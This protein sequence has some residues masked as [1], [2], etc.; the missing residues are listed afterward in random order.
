MR[1]DAAIWML[2]AF[3]AAFVVVALM[4]PDLISGQQRLWALYSLLVLAYVGSAGWVYMRTNPSSA[5]RNALLWIV[6][7]V[8]LA[9]G[10]R[11][12]ERLAF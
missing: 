11:L 12:W 1:R 2:L 10:Y 3:G 5:V 6:I 7:F 4:R 9:F 8:L